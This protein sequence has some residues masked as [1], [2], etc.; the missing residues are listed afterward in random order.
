MEKGLGARRVEDAMDGVLR[1]EIPGQD[2]FKLVGGQGSDERS[3]GGERG[4]GPVTWAARTLTSWAARAAFVGGIGT[5]GA[6]GEG[7]LSAF[8]CPVGR[9]TRRGRED[10]D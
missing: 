7:G 3:D 2:G 10:A 6:A 1:V 4:P 9:L 5:R 8:F